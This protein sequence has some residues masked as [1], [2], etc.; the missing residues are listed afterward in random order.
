MCPPPDV[1]KAVRDAFA[2]ILYPCGDVR[3][4][5][6]FVIVVRGSNGERFVIGT[7][8]A[9]VIFFK[10]VQAFQIVAT[11]MQ[12]ECGEQPRCSAVAVTAGMNRRELI[13]SDTGTDR[14]R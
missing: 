4:G 2:E 13:V 6:T 1:L 10:R 8:V 3:F 12:D 9:G 5:A 11:Q 7:K 14:A